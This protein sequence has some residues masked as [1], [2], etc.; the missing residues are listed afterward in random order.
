[1]KG[2]R[3]QFDVLVGGELIAS[4]TRNLWFRWFKSV[5]WPD[6]DHVVSEIESRMDRR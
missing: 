2:S 5:G 6:P 1:V 4:R 3:A